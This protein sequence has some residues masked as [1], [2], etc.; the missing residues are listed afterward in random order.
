[1][2]GGWSQVSYCWKRNSQVSKK[3]RLWWTPGECGLVSH[4]HELMCVYTHTYI[5]GCR[6]TGYYTYTC[7]LVLSTETALTTGINIQVLV[8]KYHSPRKGT[9]TPCRTVWFEN[10]DRERT[11]WAQSISS[12]QK[13]WKCW[14]KLK[15]WAHNQKDLTNLRQS[16]TAKA[17]TT[18]TTEKIM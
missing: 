3:A 8:S 10:S 6:D 11:G 14:Q 9:R 7:H 13:L 15:G 1:M 18:W 4:Q 12:F 17:G 2:V 5:H 16:T